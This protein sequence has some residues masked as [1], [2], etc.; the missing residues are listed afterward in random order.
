MALINCPECGAEISDKAPQCVKCGTP[1]AAAPKSVSIRFP[2]WRGQIVNNK[3]YV[4]SNGRE[5]A[6]CKQGET[7]TF[8]CLAPME[9]QIV[10]KGW[11]GKPETTVNPG[12]KYNVGY[13]GFGKIYL[14]KVDL[15]TGG[16]SQ[17]SLGIGIGIGF[18][19]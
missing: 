4:Y 13:R 8:E 17:G 18:S 3:C 2:V 14:E 15:L 9:I 19:N 11:F 5:I 16:A 10:V 7:V 12:D 6:K 1:I